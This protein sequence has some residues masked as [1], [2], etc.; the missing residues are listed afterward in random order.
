MLKWVI[1]LGIFAA[2][3]I[4]MFMFGRGFGYQEAYDNVSSVIW[5]NRFLERKVERL[6]R[7]YTEAINTM[8]A[9][10]THLATS[11]D[12]CSTTAPSA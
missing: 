1:I 11:D 10:D 7:E 3:S 8:K 12:A 5:R 9:P 2:Y 4:I 6:S